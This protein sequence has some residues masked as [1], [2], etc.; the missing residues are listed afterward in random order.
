MCEGTVREEQGRNTQWKQ[1]ALPA[2][3]VR[4]DWPVERTGVL[5]SVWVRTPGPPFPRGGIFS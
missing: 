4:Q 5:R 3:S 2:E 1:M